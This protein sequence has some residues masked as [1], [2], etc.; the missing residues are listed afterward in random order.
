[1]LIPFMHH[2]DSKL[3]PL[4]HGQHE[5]PLARTPPEPMKINNSP[6]PQVLIPEG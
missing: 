3:G 5:H 2:S 6:Q 1:M 4:H